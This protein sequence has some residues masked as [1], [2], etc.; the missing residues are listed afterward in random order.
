[1]RLEGKRAIV[2]GGGAGLGRAI[3]G[4][5]AAEGARVAVLDLDEAAAR[6]A[7]AEI[8]AAG[9]DAIGVRADVAEDESVAIAFGAAIE[10]FGGLDVLV[11]NAG[12][13][14]RPGPAIDI[15]PAEIDR[16]LTV[17]VRSIFHTTRHA[18]ARLQESQGTIINLAS[19]AALRPR[20]GMAWYNASKGAIVNLT[21]SLAAEYAPLRIRVNAIAPA[22]AETPMTKFILGDDPGGEVEQA[23][24]ATIPLGR[25]TTGADIAA[26]AVFLASDE[27]SF[28]T[29]VVLP[30]DGGRMVA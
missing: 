20:P 22:L 15:D 24:L 1:M 28:I 26:A 21:Q 19:N 11:N 27:A 7:A 10:T 23:V 2:T 8:A 14:Q 12:I 17:N 16:I 6:E 9:G 5:F 3:A 13:A 29:G 4:R 25:L 30:V 18:L